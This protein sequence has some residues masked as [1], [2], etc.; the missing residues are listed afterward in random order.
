M[1][2][3]NIEVP[4]DC[5]VCTCSCGI[6]LLVTL[7]SSAI[8]T[9]GT[10]F[11]YRGRSNSS[12]KPNR[13]PEKRMFHLPKVI[14]WHCERTRRLSVKRRREWLARTDRKDLKKLDNIRVCGHHLRVKQS[15]LILSSIH[16][17]N[18]KNC[19]FR[20]QLRCKTNTFSMIVADA[21]TQTDLKIKGLRTIEVDRQNLAS[22][23]DMFAEQA[24]QLT[25]TLKSYNADNQRLATELHNSEK[26]KEQLEITKAVQ[27][28]LLGLYNAAWYKPVTVKF[29]T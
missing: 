17:T 4:I 15:V 9:I 5:C 24:R 11:G 12:A 8:M 25:A 23:F 26:R 29:S 10:L 6:C 2:R 20:G 18:G 22:E 19:D 16:L 7:A 3:R 14:T 21:V 1:W 27:F 28:D 13:S